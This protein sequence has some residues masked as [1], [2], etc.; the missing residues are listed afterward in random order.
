MTSRGLDAAV[1]ELSRPPAMRIARHRPR[2]L[3][4]ELGHDIG[5]TRQMPDHPRGVHAI[6]WR[7]ALRVIVSGGDADRVVLTN[8]HDLVTQLRVAVALRLA[9]TAVIDLGLRMMMRRGARPA[10]QRRGAVAR[11]RA[12]TVVIDPGL[13]MMMR[14]VARPAARQGDDLAEH[15]LHY[16]GR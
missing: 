14:R 9:E 2:V 15:E 4:G 5:V 16:I 12:E 8:L 7:R 10:T 13:R 6:A 1:T 3:G 11:R